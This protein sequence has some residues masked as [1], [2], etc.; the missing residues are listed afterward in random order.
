MS[1]QTTTQTGEGKLTVEN[2]TKRFGGLTAVDDVTFEID[3]GSITGLIGPNGAGKTT[4]FN[5]INGFLEPEEGMVQIDGN[6]LTQTAPHTHAENG[7]ARTFQLVKPFGNLSVVENVMVGSYLNESSREV[8]RERAYETLEFLG[9]D[10]IADQSV[11][12]L[13]VAEK[14]KMEL[15][16]SLATDPNILLVDEIVAGLQQDEMNEITDAL[17]YIN[18]ER[19]VTVILIEHVM[20]AVMDVSE[21]I[22]VLN[23]GSVIADDQPEAISDN[24]SVVEAYLGER[25]QE[26]QEENDA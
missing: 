26:Q 21:R 24:D 23:E 3:P 13:T 18:K 25:W 11:E 2:V 7:M 22:I 1:Q 19:G 5:V 8:A 12:Q 6:D 20:E 14:K 4:L 15:C 9:L 10:P 17:K 16:R